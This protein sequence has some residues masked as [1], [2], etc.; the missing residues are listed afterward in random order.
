MCCSNCSNDVRGGT[1]EREQF[2]SRN[3]VL[4][5]NPVFFG[6]EVRRAF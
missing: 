2:V 5:R 4:L 1:P 6:E 3:A